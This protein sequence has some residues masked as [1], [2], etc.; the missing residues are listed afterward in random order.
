M[1]RLLAVLAID[2]IL[3]LPTYA[4][5]WHIYH[6]TDDHNLGLLDKPMPATYRVDMQ[7]LVSRGDKVYANTQAYFFPDPGR[8]FPGEV[9]PVSANC[10]KALINLEIGPREMAWQRVGSE[11]WLPSSVARGKRSDSSIFKDSN[12]YY[13]RMYNSLFS[14]LCQ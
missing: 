4:Q 14:I 13:D 10:A 9:I 6:R 2:T 12:T 1:K 7:S 5:T 8:S 11:W 3:M